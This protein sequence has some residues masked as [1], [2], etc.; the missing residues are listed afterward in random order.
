M[1]VIQ[2]R[3]ADRADGMDTDD[4]EGAALRAASDPSAFAE[5]YVMH[6][7][8]VFR[9]LRARVQDEDEALDLTADTFERA[10]GSISRYAPRGGGI[11]AWLFRIA[12]NTAVDHARRRRLRIPFWPMATDVRASENDEPES[13]A[14]AAHEHHRLR[15]LLADLPD[16]QRDAIALR[17]G[18]GLTAREIAVVIGKSEEA[19]QK[20]MSRALR[21]LKETYR[22]ER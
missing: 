2:L 6:R 9:Y 20:L 19:T 21:R 7:D 15:L 8:A 3:T 14:L 22:D 4:G 18:A 13:S 1:E 12:R 16:I 10:L 17:Y 5:V 11:R